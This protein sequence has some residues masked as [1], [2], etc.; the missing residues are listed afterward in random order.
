MLKLR[1]KKKMQR[2][3][4]HCQIPKHKRIEVLHRTLKKQPA[5]K[6]RKLLKNKKKIQPKISHNQTSSITKPGASSVSMSALP[7]FSSRKCS[8]TDV[9]AEGS[10]LRVLSKTVFFR[11]RNCVPA[12]NSPTPG[13]SCWPSAYGDDAEGDDDDDDGGAAFTAK[14]LPLET[15]ASLELFTLLPMLAV[16]CVRGTT[17]KICP[18][19]PSPSPSL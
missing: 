4:A 12:T 6:Q 15:G 1:K 7:S 10:G 19:S 16:R 18:P 11:S 13:V 3:L 5:Q 2:T 8:I 14:L 9:R 17:V